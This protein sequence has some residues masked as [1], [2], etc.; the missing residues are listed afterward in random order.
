MIIDNNV[1]S[2]YSVDKKLLNE[3]MRGFFGYG[4]LNAPYWFIGKEE[5]GGKDLE[6]N[7]RRIHTWKTLGKTITV[8]MIDYHFKLGFTAEQL[9]NIQSTWT[10]LTQAL[11]AMEGKEGTKEERRFYQRHKLGRLDGDNCCLELMPMASRSTG[12]WLWESI[13]KDYYQI[14]DRKEYMNVIAPMRIVRLQEL[15]G[16]YKPKLVV[17][18][19]SQADYIRYWEK[20]TNIENWQWIQ[21]TKVMKYGW[22]KHENQ[23]FVIVTHPTTPG[24]TNKDYPV[25]GAFIRDNKIV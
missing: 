15:I 7:F 8:D 12:K 13:F 4:N 6:E 14:N 17:L 25:V 16:R 19:S 20:I 24:I 21:V 22:Y 10:K 2:K 3:F 1:S 5:G 18:Y 23:L 9:N 11:I